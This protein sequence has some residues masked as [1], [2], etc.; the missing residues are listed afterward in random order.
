MFSSS[1]FV[2]LSMNCKKVFFKEIAKSKIKYLLLR[3]L[4]VIQFTG[5]N[6]NNLLRSDPS[7]SITG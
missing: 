1:L 3:L 5:S 4:H 6:A 7:M 2:E